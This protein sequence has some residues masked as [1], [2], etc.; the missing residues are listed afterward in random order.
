MRQKSCFYTTCMRM[1]CHATTL[2][3]AASCTTSAKGVCL[4]PAASIWKLVRIARIPQNRY[5]VKEVDCFWRF[6][7]FGALKIGVGDIP[8]SCSNAISSERELVL[9]NETVLHVKTL[10]IECGSIEQSRWC[11]RNRDSSDQATF[12]SIFYC[13]ILVNLCEL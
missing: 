13:P 2:P 8:V 11:S 3:S 9:L 6:F 10:L 1:H 12:F 7:F 5:I 4:S